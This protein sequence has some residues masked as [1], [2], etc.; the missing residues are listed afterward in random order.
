MDPTAISINET[1]NLCRF[2]DALLGADFPVGAFEFT[3]ELDVDEETEMRNV[4]TTESVLETS[5]SGCVICFHFVSASR[6]SGGLGAFT[7]V[8]EPKNSSFSS[9][10]F[11]HFPVS[12]QDVESSTFTVI[13]TWY[14]RPDDS[15][16]KSESGSFELFPLSGG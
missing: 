16:Y 14:E 7:S 12:P 2:C 9:S 4:E 6:M 8:G 1:L 5:A 3:A 15:K 10:R 11:I 13:E